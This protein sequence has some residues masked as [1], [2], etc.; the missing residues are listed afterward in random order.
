[1]FSDF[2]T[3]SSVTSRILPEIINTLPFSDTQVT[4][5]VVAGE[6]VLLAITSSSFNAAQIFIIPMNGG[7]ARKIPLDDNG[8]CLVAGC[9]GHAYLGTHAGRLL[10]LEIAAGLLTELSP[11][12]PEESFQVAYRSANG[13]LYFGSTPSGLVVELDPV[14]DVVSHYYHWHSDEQHPHHATAFV[15]LPDGRLATFLSGYDH[16]TLLISPGSESWQRLK[17]AALAG[18]HSVSQAVLFDEKSLLVAAAPGKLLFL[19]SA[20]DLSLLRPLPSLPD[21]DTVYCLQRS[22][23]ELLA[24]GVSGALYRWHNDCWE[25]LARPLPNDPIIFTTQ[26]DSRLAGVSCQ[27]RLLQSSTDHRVFNISPLPT[28]ELTGLAITAMGMAPDRNLYFAMAKN[29]RLGC[30]NP[31]EDDEAQESFIAAPSYGEVSALGFAG[32]RLLIGFAN[33]CGVMSYY[34]ELPYR[35]MENPRLLGIAG[36]ERRRPQGPMVHHENNVYFSATS[37][38]QHNNGA[39]VRID[40]QEYRVTLFDAV[41]PGQNL[42]SL[43]ADRLSGLLIAGGS[44]HF[45]TLHAGTEASAALAFWSP[46]EEK[47][48]R[49]IAPWVDAD[50]LHVWAAEGGRIY[51]TDNAERLAIISSEGE[52]LQESIFPLGQIT[53]LITSGEGALYG[54]A[55]GWFFHLDVENNRVERLTEA[56]GSH[57]VEVRR[58]QFAYTNDGR[59]GIVT[60]L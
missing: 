36:K 44:L 51:V 54:L 45:G 38:S 17:I 27:G 7:D 8:A 12:L 42:T 15:D 28:K 30:W 53:S 23:E 24:S 18:Q 5:Q 4:T 13:K 10:R 56:T 22:G 26:P 2:L 34:P 25:F 20:E 11:P 33:S 41:L 49:Q 60:L 9:D 40:P 52:L 16:E 14:T 37:L 58:G 47:T 21:D 46:Y 29:M 19:L 6:T 57:L 35:L 55:G 1:M 3:L 31:D 32:E 43:K 39:I 50:I 48:I 59:I